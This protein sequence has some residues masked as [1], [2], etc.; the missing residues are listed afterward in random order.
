MTED[1]LHYIWQFKLFDLKNLHTSSGEK[2]EILH[3]GEHNTDAGP[4]F[5]NAKIKI[6]NTLWAGNVE[7]HLQSSDW[8]NHSHQTDKSYDN[9]ILHVVY[10]SDEVVNRT[11]GEKIPCLELKNRINQNVYENYVQLMQ[12]RSWIPCQNQ[13][14]QVDEFVLKNWLDRLLMERMERKTSSIEN[15]LKQ[16]HHNWEETFYQS[17]ARNFGLKINADPFEMLAQ[18]LPLKI[19]AKHK[20]NLMQLESLIFGQAGMLEGKFKDDY[21]RQI[22]KEYNFL[23]KKYSLI[24]M[25]GHLWKFLRLMPANFP[26]IRIAQF[27][28]LIFQSSHLFSKI[29]E[30]KNMKDIEKYFEAGTSSYWQSHYRF[31]RLSARREKHFGKN[32]IHVL[33]INTVAPFLF[34]YGK[35]K[36]D[37]EFKDKA[38]QLL[39][40]I[41]PEKNAI[42]SKW[43]ELSVS[44]ASAYDSQAL[45]QLKNEYCS[46]KKCLHCVIGNQILSG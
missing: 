37:E 35:L 40:K 9:I 30:T 20:N 36:G 11:D 10:D 29:L 28:R 23:Q 16:N 2:I 39:Q 4:D 32:A 15:A 46:R 44:V 24:P 42:I 45:L 1:F 5:F 33:L 18:S 19:L 27:A 25:Y 12:S 41:A 43:Q 17:L 21:P 3:C 7:I 6:N 26:T 22:Q 38:F 34:V 31:D 13:I 14:Q 8:K